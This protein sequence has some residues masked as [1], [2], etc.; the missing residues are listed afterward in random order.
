MAETE[1]RVPL[2]ATIPADLKRQL[3]QIVQAPANSRTLEMVVEEALRGW[4]AEEA[5]A[6]LF[7]VALAQTAEDEVGANYLIA[8]QEVLATDWR[9]PDEDAAWRDL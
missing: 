4:L 7:A 1:Q 8:S 6:D 2:A 5:A 3:D 9:R